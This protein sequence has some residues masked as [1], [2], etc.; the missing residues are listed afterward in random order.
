MLLFRHRLRFIDQASSNKEAVR[1][2]Q[3]LTQMHKNHIYR[4]IFRLIKNCMC[5][6]ENNNFAFYISTVK[7]KIFFTQHFDWQ[8]HQTATST[9]SD[10]W[11]HPY[12]LDR[13]EFPI[14]LCQNLCSI[15][16]RFQPFFFFLSNIFHS[17][18][19]IFE[20]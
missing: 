3:V 13:R 18:S 9:F 1:M 17:H 12:V 11:N 19:Y 14:H 8:P 5:M 20:V 10:T 16:K 7:K 2:H 6:H 15:V 4:W